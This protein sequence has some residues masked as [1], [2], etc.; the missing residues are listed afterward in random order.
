M[1]IYL[2]KIIHD[3]LLTP[4]SSRPH[5]SAPCKTILKCHYKTIPWY[6]RNTERK[7]TKISRNYDREPTSSFVELNIND[8]FIELLYLLF[9]PLRFFGNLTPPSLRRR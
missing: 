9:I 2:N 8:D 3:P 4:Y 6:R 1:A 5:R 7:N